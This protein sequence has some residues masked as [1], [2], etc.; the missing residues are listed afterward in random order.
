MNEL[1]LYEEWLL[2]CGRSGY[3]QHFRFELLKFECRKT[4]DF[5]SFGALSYPMSIF[6]LI[7]FRCFY[8]WAGF[9]R[10]RAASMRKM[11]KFTTFPFELLHFESR[12]TLDIDISK[13]WC[14]LGG[15]GQRI[16]PF[17]T[18]CHAPKLCLW[19]ELFIVRFTYRKRF[20]NQALKGITNRR[21]NRETKNMFC[22]LLSCN[23]QA[24]PRF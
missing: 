8:E 7:E 16:R 11:R 22:R 20:T 4:L 15:L 21:I 19:L 2:A 10:R 1:G 12:K 23:E 24:L 9:A 3:L 13:K 5:Y 17:R 14:R 18:H 6:V